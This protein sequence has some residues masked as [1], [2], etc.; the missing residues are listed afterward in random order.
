MTLSKNLVRRYQNAYKRKF[1]EDI[2][3]KEAEK[4]LFDIATLIKFI[5]KERR[6]NHGE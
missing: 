3:E 5:V 1:N 2:S 6:R 4:E